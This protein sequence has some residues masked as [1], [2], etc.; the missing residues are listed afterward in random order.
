[1][2]TQAN[3]GTD[4]WYWI[5]STHAQGRFY[6]DHWRDANGNVLTLQF[7][8]DG[9]YI[10]KF[11]NICVASASLSE[12]SE[13]STIH[14]GRMD[15]DCCFLRGTAEEARS[16][17]NDFSMPFAGEVIQTPNG[18]GI[19]LADKLMGE[20][21]FNNQWTFENLTPPLA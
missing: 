6:E 7:L 17:A 14:R 13:V 9:R 12:N 2:A 19:A 8:H 1:L 15:A 4:G 21:I 11:N 20:P 5:N 3:I 16:L 18:Y 10:L